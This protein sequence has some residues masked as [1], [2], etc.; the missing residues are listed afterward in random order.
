M[1]CVTERFHSRSPYGTFRLHLPE[2]PLAV[3]QR[4]Q[5]QKVTGRFPPTRGIHDI[6]SFQDRDESNYRVYSDKGERRA[7]APRRQD[8]PVVD[9]TSGFTSVGADAEDGNHKP[10]EPLVCKDHRPQSATPYGRPITSPTPELR[11][12]NAPWETKN[13]GIFVFVYEFKQSS[14]V[15]HRSRI[16]NLLTI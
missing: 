2:D 7:E 16:A 5:R 12:I 3:G 6:I 13:K 1:A 15:F 8:T 11:T 10:I 4:T 9:P 14:L